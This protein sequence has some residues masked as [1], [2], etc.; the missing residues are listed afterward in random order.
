MLSSQNGIGVCVFLGRRSDLEVTGRTDLRERELC[1][2][3][4]ELTLRSAS[5]AS[6]RR[7]LG[8]SRVAHPLHGPGDRFH[9]G[10]AAR[11]KSIG[12]SVGSTRGSTSR[13]SPSR[14][15]SRSSAAASC[16]GGAASVV[17]H[18]GRRSY[19]DEAA[20]GAVRQHA[21]CE[22]HLF[23]KC[24]DERGHNQR[25]VH[26]VTSAIAHARRERVL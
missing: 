22:L 19:G 5:Y 6:Q 15:P 18:S 10:G 23:G 16:C 4:L 17:G 11:S 20:A 24:D 14:R 1:M 25:V 13:R 26:A 8:M 12:Q 21:L 9:R 2:H 3:Q 7:R